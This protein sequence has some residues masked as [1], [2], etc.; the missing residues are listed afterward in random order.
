MRNIV[1]LFFA[2]I[3]CLPTIAQQRI[4]GKVIDE[5]GAPQEFVNVVC[6]ALPDSVFV[7]GTVTDQSGEFSI[8]CKQSA[9]LLKV[10]SV[11]F[12]TLYR[13]IGGANMGVLTLV[14]DAQLLSEVVIKGDLPKVGIKGD[15]LVTNVQNS[16]LSKMGSASDVLARVPG[17]VK[18]K[19]SFEVFGKGAP[20]FYI[21]GRQVRDLS[22]LEQLNS[23]DIKSVEVVANPGARYDASVKAVVRIQT[24]KRKGDGFGVDTRSTYSQ[25]E[26]TD[27]RGTLNLNYRHNDLDVF[28][29]VN[30]LRNNRLQDSKL[31]QETNTP[32]KWKQENE[33]H[34]TGL[35]ERIEATSGMNYAF[36]EQHS[37]GIRYQMTARPKYYSTSQTK[38]LVL[39]NDVFYDNWL[40]HSLYKNEYR[41]THQL[42]GYYLR[43]IGRFEIS[44]NMDYYS[45]VHQKITQTQ[46][47]SQ[48]EDDRNIETA[49]DVNNKLWANKLIVSYPLWKGKLLFGGE[50]S[51]AR[52][53]DDY[54]GNSEF[55]STSY[56]KIREQNVSS[57]LEYNRTFNFGQLIV[58]V[59]YE[60]ALFNYYENDKLLQEQSRKFNNIFP[61]L[62]FNTELGQT[63][64]QVSYTSKINRPSYSML[65]N[66]VYYMN[67][68]TMQKGNPLLKPTIINDWSLV[69]SY[70]FIQLMLSY[71]QRLDDIIY[72][73]EEMDE[74]SAA[75]LVQYQNYHKIPVLNGYINI[76]PT[77]GCWSPSVGIGIAKQWLSFKTEDETIDMDRPMVM[78]SW[79]NT[80]SFSNNWNVSL[81]YSFQGKGHTQNVYIT[82][83]IHV[84][85]FSVRKE[86]LKNAL[87]IELRGDDLFHGQKD[88]NRVR[89]NHISIYQGNSYDSREFSLTVRYKWNMGRSKY[90]GV[91]AGNSEMKRLK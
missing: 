67:R 38:S 33:L 62:S 52:R 24:V 60:N 64:L 57:F 83:N 37:M 42:N 13:P 88:G 55:I 5:S 9:D 47:N 6:L 78:G 18:K 66:N 82:K 91:G 22:E 85:N 39:K 1:L 65:S 41:P 53:K 45:D 50:Y 79:N 48:E 8:V 15:A 75:T 69:G 34:E 54:V 2:V 56:S 14:S 31:T 43:S 30:Y 59:R 72:W 29:S 87:S 28:G 36:S 21:N 26:N 19:D 77:I 81:D 68:F 89:M 10:S 90:K 17:I 11:G 63:Q 46:E 51:Y 44:L 32:V 86:L 74:N 7:D 27:W 40:A 80:F 4:S 23:G 12:T 71:Q 70:K 73:G 61:T 16:I 84:W 20:L 3:F 49:N 25:S 58:G 35:Q 76:A